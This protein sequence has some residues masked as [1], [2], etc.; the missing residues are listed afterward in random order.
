MGAEY[1]RMLFAYNRWANERLVQRAA[2]LTEDEFH[3]D[4]G[5]SMASV[6]G[7]LAHSLAAEAVWLARFRGESPS[8]LLGGADFPTITALQ[9]RW[10]LHEAALSAWL[11]SLGEAELWR[12]VRYR[13]TGGEEQRQVLAY[14]MAHVVNHSTQ[15][16]AEAAVGLTRLEHSPGDIDLILW[17]R[18]GRK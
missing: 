12:E 5:L 15:F 7:S 13:T 18:R 9:E 11:A 3:R 6:A 4:L 14:L 10:A 8:R 1:F 2:E 17:L 16:R